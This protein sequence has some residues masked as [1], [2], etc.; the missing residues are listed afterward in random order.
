MAKRILKFFGYDLYFP[1][2]AIAVLTYFFPFL[3]NLWVLASLGFY[4][5]S[6]YLEKNQEKKKLIKRNKANLRR[7]YK[8]SEVL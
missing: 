2:L 5:F 4:L 3:T 8:S 1:L 6:I 7:D